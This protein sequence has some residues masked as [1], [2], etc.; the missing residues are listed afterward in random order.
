MK[1]IKIP[2]KLKN[3]KL[4]AGI[5]IV[6][7]LIAVGIAMIPSEAEKAEGNLKIES[8][9]PSRLAFA[10]EE[11][12]DLMIVMGESS[13][14]TTTLL[15]DVVLENDELINVP[16]YFLDTSYYTASFSDD[17]KDEQQIQSAINDYITF[18][19]TYEVE[20]L[21]TIVNFED[22]EVSG[23]LGKYV[24]DEYTS[25]KSTDEE[26]ASLLE[27]ANQNVA[28]WLKSIK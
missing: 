15:L 9:S 13:A 11:K 16:V 2:E 26:K 24:S 23:S 10:I 17:S 14:K 19:N 4:W 5:G 28:K 8:L 6:V 21:P 12:Q 20:N 27:D 22:G 3:K 18:L 7:L 25:A 1:N